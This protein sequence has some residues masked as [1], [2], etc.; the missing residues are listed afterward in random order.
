MTMLSSSRRIIYFAF[1]MPAVFLVMFAPLS[2]YSGIWAYAT[3]SDTSVF[4]LIHFVIVPTCGTVA[5]ISGFIVLLGRSFRSNLNRLV[6][7]FLLCIG[8]LT[9]AYLAWPAGDV[10]YRIFV[11]LPAIV[12]VMLI[13]HLWHKTVN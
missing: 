4:S 12:A 6:H 3:G 10:G 9:S 13:H 7:T 2:I 11:S 1:G 8:V 5:T